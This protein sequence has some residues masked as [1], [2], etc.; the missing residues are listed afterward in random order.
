MPRSAFVLIACRGADTPPEPVSVVV[1]DDSS[2][3]IIN[4][5]VPSPDG[6]R[7]AYTQV[8]AGGRSAVFVSALD[9]SNAVRVSHGVWDDAP[10]WSPD[11][12]WIAY[13]GEDPNFD[14]YV[15]PS[16]GSGCGSTADFGPRI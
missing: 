8:V 9:G 6:S 10:T 2:G 12:K 16:D 1:V 7:L 11:G 5:A 4:S 13:Q 15:V 14:V 3:R